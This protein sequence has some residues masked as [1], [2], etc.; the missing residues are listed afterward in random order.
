ML[1]DDV[2]SEAVA[3]VAVVPDSVAE[4]VHAAA[5]TATTASGA[6]VNRRRRLEY[7]SVN[8]PAGGKLRRD[9]VNSLVA[10]GNG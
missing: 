10:G 9:I 1:A 5:A 7:G 2:D 6:S 3:D 4:E 8:R